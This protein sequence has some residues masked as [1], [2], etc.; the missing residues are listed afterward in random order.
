ME[1]DSYVTQ[2]RAKSYFNFLHTPWG[3][4]QVDLTPEAKIY[5]PTCGVWSTKSKE[6]LLTLIKK[7]VRELDKSAKMEY[8]SKLSVFV[9][10]MKDMESAKKMLQ[11]VKKVVFYYVNNRR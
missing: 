8:A 9:I 4:Y 10:E 5:I 1:W 2:T 7:R 3:Q 6:K 11:E